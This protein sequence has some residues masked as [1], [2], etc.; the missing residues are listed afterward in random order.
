MIIIH[1]GIPC[2]NACMYIC[3]TEYD[4]YIIYNIMLQYALLYYR[5]F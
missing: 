1:V 2:R 5:E 4:M 3:N